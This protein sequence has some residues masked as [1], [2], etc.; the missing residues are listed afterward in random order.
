MSRLDGPEADRPGTARTAGRQAASSPA[1]P[2]R[3]RGPELS[4][5]T[6][7][8]RLLLASDPAPATAGQRLRQAADYGPCAACGQPDAPRVQRFADDHARVGRMRFD[9]PC[10]CITAHPTADRPARDA[11]PHFSTC[12]LLQHQ[13][14]ASWR[15]D[16]A[17]RSG[18]C[19]RRVT[20]HAAMV[21]SR[22]LGFGQYHHG[23]QPYGSRCTMRQRS[24]R[25]TSPPIVH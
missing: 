12:G 23:S 6:W 25:R 19:A 17:S 9:R 3:P 21:Q 22:V 16:S 1:A 18:S 11:G 20:L 14:G 15:G 13:P 8:R 10:G 5:R 4:I 7:I 24:C 2:P